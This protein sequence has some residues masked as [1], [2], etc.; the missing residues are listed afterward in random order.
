MTTKLELNGALI[1][2]IHLQPLPGAPRY[3]GSMTTVIDAAL[4]DAEA[5]ASAGVDA[6]IVENFGDVPFPRG[7]AGPETVAALAVVADRVSR[8]VDQPLGI[9]VL[10]NDGPSALAIA[11]AT[12]ARFVRVNVLSW[13]RLTDQ[14]VIEG[15]AAAVLRA[16]S[17]LGADH[18][19]ILADVAVKHSAPLAPVDPVEEARDVVERAMADAVI[20]TGAATS[21]AVDLEV[22]GAVAAAVE[23]PV[24]AGSGVTVATAAEVRRAAD[25]AIVGS[26]MMAG[27]APGG[28]VDLDRARALVE[29]WRAGATARR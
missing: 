2:M 14:G 12:G 15:D 24:I 9:N 3:A 29:A 16:R 20:V 10:R 5:L 23:V 11:V 25:A 7:A 22:L 21:A 28:L 13:A 1:G 26:A 4:G 19:A 18:V 17:A 6:V 8:V 27:G